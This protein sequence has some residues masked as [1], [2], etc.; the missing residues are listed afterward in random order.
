METIITKTKLVKQFIPYL[1]KY[2]AVELFLLLIMLI[3]SIGSLATPYVLKIIIDDIFPK[4]NYAN[5]VWILSF[6][7]V[8]YVVRIAGAMGTDVLYAKISQGI[9]SD[10]RK[11][12]FK[13][14]LS[15]PIN[16]YQEVKAG[17][18]LFT[19]MNDVQNIQSALSSFILNFLSDTLT[20]AG[21]V[22]MLGILNIKLTTI[23][24]VIVP[25]I[26]FSIRKFTPRLQSSF[27]KVQENQE[28]LNSFI[29]E[30]LRNYRIIRSY[31]THLHE[32]KN[33]IEL[34]KKTIERNVSN[35]LI[36]TVNSNL[37]T[38]F[39][40]IGPVIVL[41]YGGKDV[42]TGT[43][44]IGALIAFIQ[45]LNRLYAPT[46]GIMNSY[47]NFN[48]AIVSM[49]R[50][51]VYLSENEKGAEKPATG[52]T[53]PVNSLTFKNVSFRLN[54]NQILKNVNFHF[55]KG[56]I[57]GIVGPNGSG[58]S[59]VINLL[60]KFW[61]PTTG[62]IYL[63]QEEVSIDTI[64]NWIDVVG[65]I[66]KENQLFNDK[67]IGNIR[68]GS[69]EA[70]VKGL[71]KAVNDSQLQEIINGLPEGLETTITETGS[72]L[73]DG[74]KQRISIARAL[75][76]NPQVII[77]DEATSALD[78]EVETKLLQ[79][80]KAFYR[81]SIIIIITH[82][83]FTISQFDYVYEI[84]NKTITKEGPPFAF[85]EQVYDNHRL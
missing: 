49:E 42:F 61:K 62:E 19:I 23:S 21:I 56:K 43:M 36:N 25:I 7:V 73:S 64:S 60:C 52:K 45:Y 16:F 59:T 82:R 51:S 33:L 58:K 63:N 55:E 17:D 37:I 70:D 14:V 71:T 11:D 29:L 50:V 30:K 28:L 41:I 57:Y 44:T 65:L 39:V 5:L 27:R 8:T 38:F 47:N 6:L 15:K 78:V 67:L 54:G 12:M 46:I 20:V 66:E 32:E 10:I 1:K 40:A 75:L 24:L 18:V 76:K 68:Y 69:F 79:T 81:D 83:L 13:T 80:L 35:A 34:Q 9:I 2:I 53:I 77:L 26:L 74:Q 84:G 48:K 3:T 4:G 72:G 22:V 31:N 85:K